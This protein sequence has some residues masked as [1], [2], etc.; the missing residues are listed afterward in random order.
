[1]EATRLLGYAGATTSL[2]RPILLGGG[3]RELVLINVVLIF[4]LVLGVG[5]N[6]VTL[7]G[8]RGP[9]HGRPRARWCALAKVDPQGWRVFARHFQYRDFYPARAHPF[10]PRGGGPPVH[11]RLAGCCCASIDGR[12]QGLA[13]LLNWGALVA[14]GVVLNKDGSFTAAWEYRGPDLHS[15]TREEVGALSHQVNRRLLGLGSDWMLSVDAIRALARPL[16]GRRRGGLPRSGDGA[17]RRRAPPGL[18]RGRH[19]FETRVRPHADPHA[20]GRDRGP[21]GALARRR[22]AAA[23]LDWHEQLAAFTALSTISRTSSAPVS[24][25]SGSTQRPFSTTSTTA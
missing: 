17:D 24:G 5:P 18:R 19:N 12:P 23:E 15:A 22:P 7:G 11:R 13:D 9:G 16:P 8:G 21:G 6:P 4:A 20:A 2:V 25:S 10:A 1:M 3:E 14:D